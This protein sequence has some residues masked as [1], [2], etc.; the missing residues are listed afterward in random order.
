MELPSPGRGA[1]AILFFQWRASTFGAEKFHG[2]M[3][4]HAGQK[5]T[6]W[7]EI[8]KVGTELRGL[9]DIVGTRVVPSVAMAFGWENWWA[10]ELPS[11]PAE[12]KLLD[13]LFA[14]Y[15]PLWRSGLVAEF[16]RP[17]ADLSGRALVCLPN[18]YL[19]D[20]AAAAQV[21][22]YAR[23]GGVVVS[24][25]SWIVDA[26]NHVPLGPYP[27]PWTEMLGAEVLD[28]CPYPEAKSGSVRASTGECFEC[29]L[30]S[31]AI[32]EREAEAVATYE[33]GPLAG[34]PAVL[35]HPHG[36]GEVFYLGTRLDEA[37]MA[38]V[39]DMAAAR[40]G[41]T[42][43]QPLPSGVEAV[44]RVA[45]GKSFLFLLNHSDEAVD[46]KLEVPGVDLLSGLATSS[47]RLLPRGVAVVRE[48]EIVE[49][50]P[51]R[52]AGRA[53]TRP[54]LLRR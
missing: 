20:D 19:V 9:A 10:L 45:Q 40:A 34:G 2:A 32:V 11:K 41:I 35:R 44:R 33:V 51:G 26:N 53:T 21:E 27:A 18:L 54:K 22:H 13:Q 14:Y 29:D 23:A 49:R 50:A 37:G 4:P 12:V 24:F 1:D 31:E 8:V 30:W 48:D 5:T 7:Q 6:S 47:A 43:P 16:V 28:F 25:F 39:L 46:V 42:L 36:E 38:W 52:H 17:G 3:L 15:R